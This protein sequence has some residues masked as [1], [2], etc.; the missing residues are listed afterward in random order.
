MVCTVI[1]FV[2]SPRIE[3]KFETVLSFDWI[4]RFTR[5]LSIRRKCLIY[6]SRVDSGMESDD[7]RIIYIW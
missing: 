7:T 3:R 1:T 2:M 5:K 6:C 4:D